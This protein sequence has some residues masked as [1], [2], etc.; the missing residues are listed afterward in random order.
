MRETPSD[1]TAFSADP[2]GQPPV[3]G[4]LH[5]PIDA[6]GEGLVLTHGAGGNSRTALLVG[7]SRAFAAAGFHV[8]RCDL[9]FRQVRAT[10]PPSP[11]PSGRPSRDAGARRAQRG[12]GW[13][14]LRRTAGEH[15][16]RRRARDRPRAPPLLVSPPSA[17]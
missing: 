12:P 1:F 3:R 13:P 15:A 5:T 8:L 17:R 7:V 6:T 14:V 10:G 11:G 16:R 4:F 9:P 2:P